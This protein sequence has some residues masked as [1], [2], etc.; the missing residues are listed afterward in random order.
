MHWLQSLDVTLFHLVNP[1][2]SSAW[3]DVL[4]P[5]CSGNRYFAPVLVLACAGMAIWGGARGRL[6]VVFL[7]LAVAL[8]DTLVCNTIKQLFSRPRPFLALSDVHVPAGI[9]RTPSGSMPS[10]HAANWFA[11][12]MVAFIYYRRSVW[13][14]VPLAALVSLSRIYNGVHYPSDVLVGAIL[15]AGYAAGG[16]WTLDAIWQW[17]GQRWFPIWHTKLPSLMNPVP[18]IPPAADVEAMPADEQRLRDTQWI[19]LGYAL[20]GLHLVVKLIYLASGK[21]DLQQDEAYQWIWS[22]HLALSYYSKPPMIAYTQF[23]STSLFGDNPFGIRFFSPVITAVISI[24]TLRFMSR[25][26]NP[27]AAFWLCAALLTVPLFAIGATLLTIDPLS[28]MFWFLALIAGWRAV[29]ADSEARISDWLWVGLWSGLGFLSKYTALFQWLCWAVFFLLWPRARP[30]LRKP[31]PYL[32][33]LINVVCTLPVLVWNHQ[34]HWITV[35]HV[36]E[37]GGLDKAWMPTPVNIWHGLTRYTT[38]FFGLETVLLN[39]FLI[40]PTVWAAVAIWRSKDRDQLSVYL[41]SMSAPVFITFFLLT[42]RSRVLPNWIAPG[43]LPLFCLSAVYWDRRWREGHHAIKLWLA[44]GMAICGSLVLVMHD[45]NLVTKIAGRPLPAKLDPLRRV[46]GWS[47]T[48]IV[49]ESARQ[50]LLG[51]GKPVFIIGGHYG[52]TSEVTFY[53][54]EAK[55]DVPDHPLAYFQTSRVPEN[56]FCFWPGY[57]DRKGQNA[58]YVQELDFYPDPPMSLEDPPI[59]DSVVQEFDSVKDLGPVF[60]EYRGRPIRRIQLAECRGLR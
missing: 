47:D 6:C 50:K 14:M 7:L 54:P 10:S 8:G 31:G 29:Q 12:A 23:L 48:A 21:I 2:L 11:G 33:L 51:E 39:P 19:A 27:R 53:L 41:F 55:S 43:I 30:Q 59:P 40:L 4:M 45:T 13:F 9:G 20:I 25:A 35:R 24:L 49:V 32:A 56:Q 15:G 18:G 57:Q 58:I 36:A 38:D 22:K 26:T 5:F 1:A 60:V 17:A 34:H 16:V 37:D 28:V 52:I 3:L 44:T 42:F 46:K